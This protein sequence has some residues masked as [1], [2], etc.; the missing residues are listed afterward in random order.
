MNRQKGKIGATSWETKNDVC[1][2]LGINPERS[3]LQSFVPTDKVAKMNCFSTFP[4]RFS[5][6]LVK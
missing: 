3:T 4:H 6:S 5:L 2:I 1:D